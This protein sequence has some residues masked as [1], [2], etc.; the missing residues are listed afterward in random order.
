MLHQESSANQFNLKRLRLS[1]IPRRKA[2]AAGADNMQALRFL[3]SPSGRLPPQAFAFAA[4]V[5]YLA[6]AA[7]HWL[8]APDMIPRGGLWPFVAAQTLLVWIWFALHA[9]RL[10]DA[11]R[12][13]GLP[14]ASAFF[15]PSRSSLLIIVTASFYTA[16]AGEVPDAN[17]GAVRWA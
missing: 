11:G 14:A 6:G 1:V 9:K 12:A 3:F 16:L 4:V 5:V 15:M 7:S 2:G 17:T 8:T 13:A 10:R